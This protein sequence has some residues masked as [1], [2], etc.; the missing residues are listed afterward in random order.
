MEPRPR[1]LGG[2]PFGIARPLRHNKESGRRVEQLTPNTPFPEGG[3][4]CGSPA[5]FQDA[6]DQY[7]TIHRAEG[8][9]HP[10]PTPGDGVK[11]CPF[12]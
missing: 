12:A 7:L 6:T 4:G 11:G 8:G 1:V 9:L 2:P 10:R 5:P 3:G